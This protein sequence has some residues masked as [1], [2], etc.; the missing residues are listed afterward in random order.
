MDALI[1]DW[2][3]PDG[4]GLEFVRQ[5]RASNTSVAIVMIT[6]RVLNVAGC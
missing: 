2:N 4:S 6:G 3:L 1:V 5:V